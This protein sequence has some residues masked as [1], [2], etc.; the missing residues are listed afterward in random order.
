VAKRHN[1]QPIDGDQNC[2]TCCKCLWQNGTFN[3]HTPLRA[4]VT[5]SFQY[6]VRIFSSSPS[7]RAAAPTA[8]P[9]QQP[10]NEA[11]SSAAAPTP[12]PNH[13]HPH[14]TL[15]PRSSSPLLFQTQR[16]Q[17]P[18]RPDSREAFTAAQ[19]AVLCAPL[20][21]ST[22]VAELERAHHL[23]MHTLCADIGTLLR[24]S[25]SCSESGLSVQRT[26]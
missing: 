3:P 23:L 8:A 25:A 14:S 22:P 16:P 20:L 21:L 13:P 5:A 2:K 12:A 24:G 18:S 7:L 15:L 11:A 10:L 19:Q 1:S 9:M 6:L 26:H 4:Q 17:A